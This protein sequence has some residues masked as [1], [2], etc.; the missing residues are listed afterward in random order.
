MAGLRGMAE[1]IMTRLDIQVVVTKGPDV[2]TWLDLHAATTE[3][4][5]TVNWSHFANGRI[6][7]FDPRPLLAAQ[8][9]QS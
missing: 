2:L 8:D 9:R 5:P 4:L 7:T 6:A 3:L 1:N